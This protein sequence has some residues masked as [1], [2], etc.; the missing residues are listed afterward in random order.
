MGDK[1]KQNKL[2]E[3]LSSYGRPIQIFNSFEEQQAYE[4]KE[5]SKL[6]GEEILYQMRRMINIAYGMHGYDPAELPKK[7]D[8]VIILP[9]KQ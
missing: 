6:S 9:G 5:M 1:N 7:H 8:I 4:F 3:P 2:N